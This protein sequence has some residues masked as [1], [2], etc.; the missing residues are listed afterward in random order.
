MMLSHWMSQAEAARHI[1]IG[2]P[3]KVATIHSQDNNM[4]R[5]EYRPPMNTQPSYMVHCYQQLQGAGMLQLQCF[6]LEPA[7]GMLHRQHW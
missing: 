4:F 5:Y 6:M 2:R 1:S 7:R 3:Y